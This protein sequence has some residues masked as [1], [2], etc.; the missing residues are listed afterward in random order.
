MSKEEWARFDQES[1]T[2]KYNES[3]PSDAV[4]SRIV[5]DGIPWADSLKGITVVT[6]KVH[7]VVTKKVKKV[8]KLIEQG[9]KVQFMYKGTIFYL[10]IHPPSLIARCVY[11]KAATLLGKK[12]LNFDSEEDFEEKFKVAIDTELIKKQESMSKE[13]W[14]K[15]E[16][17]S[18][19]A[20]CKES[21]PSDAVIKGVIEYDLTWK[22]S[23]NATVCWSMLTKRID[24]GQ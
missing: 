22:E 13:E 11:D 2:A 23:V 12:K 4:I 16:Q 21:I 15:F 7:T 6:K 20:K 14:A 3:I 9:F 5:V 10:G 17:G 1:F 18:F 8:H 24:C 19:I